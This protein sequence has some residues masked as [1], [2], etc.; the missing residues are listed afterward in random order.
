MKTLSLHDAVERVPH[1][2]SLMIDGCRGVGTL[3]SIVDALVRQCRTTRRSRRGVGKRVCRGRHERTAVRTPKGA[4]RD[5]AHDRDPRCM[6]GQVGRK[7]DVS[8]TPA[9]PPAPKLDRMDSNLPTT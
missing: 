6:V 2:A 8:L 3:E 7:A 9:P 1:G 4:M 5:R